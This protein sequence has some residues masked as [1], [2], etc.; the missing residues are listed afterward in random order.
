MFSGLHVDGAVAF[1]QVA[2]P[3]AENCMSLKATPPGLQRKRRS[4]DPAQVPTGPTY[5]HAARPGCQDMGTEPEGQFPGHPIGAEIVAVTE[6]GIARA[7]QVVWMVLD[8]QH[9]VQPA[10]VVVIAIISNAT[11]ERPAQVCVCLGDNR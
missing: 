7:Q 10:N 2:P 4:Q 5:C 3:S 8:G 1:C 6:L 11:N 9:G